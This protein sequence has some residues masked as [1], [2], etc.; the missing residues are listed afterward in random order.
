[1]TDLQK[2]PIVSVLIEGYNDSLDLGSALETVRSVAD[3]TYCLEQV[4]IILTGSDAQASRWRQALAGERRFFAVKVIGADAHYYRLK[5]L[6]AEAANGDILAFTDSDALPEKGWLEAIVRG[7]DGGAAAV[8]GLTLF[9]SEK[10]GRLSN[11][12]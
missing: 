5:N 10:G 6:A 9:G 2:R 11:L 3:Q 7:I 12:R 4:E 8:A 1:M